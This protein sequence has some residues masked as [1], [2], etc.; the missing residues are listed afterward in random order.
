MK[1]VELVGPQLLC[2]AVEDADQRQYPRL[3]Q[4]CNRPRRRAGKSRDELAA[5]HSITSSARC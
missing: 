5:V 4:R 1:A 2:A 3:R